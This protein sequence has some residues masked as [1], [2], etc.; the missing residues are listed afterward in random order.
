MTCTYPQEIERL[1]SSVTAYYLQSRNGRKLTW[2]GSLGSADLR[3]VFPAIPGKSG[4]LAKERRYEINVPTYGMIV[5][6]LFNDIGDKPLSFEEIQAKTS[7]PPQELTRTLAALAVAPKC[8]VLAKE[9]P[10][11]TV[12]PGDSFRFNEA[13]ASKTI[14]IKA[15]TVSAASKVEGEDERRVT[16]AK[17]D[18]TRAHV[19]DAAIVRIMKY[20]ASSRGS[21]RRKEERRWLTLLPGSGKSLCTR[22]S[23]ARCSRSSRGASSPRCPWSR[24]G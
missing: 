21:P 19:M 14:K 13:F 24:S 11:K 10:N 9:P 18:Q 23:S 17:T 15:P 22:S 20:V 12:R 6:L 16:E 3:C 8:R 1:H 4:V 7:I 5:L 2:V